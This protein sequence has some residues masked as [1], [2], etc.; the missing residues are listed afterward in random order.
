MGAFSLRWVYCLLLPSCLCCSVSGCGGPTYFC[1]FRYSFQLCMMSHIPSLLQHFMGRPDS[2]YH[3]E[4]NS[5]CVVDLFLCLLAVILLLIHVFSKVRSINKSESLQRLLMHFD[6]VVWMVTCRCIPGPPAFLVN[7]VI[8]EW[9]GN[10][11]MSE[12]LALC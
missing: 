6:L 8:C 1:S 5:L 3:L 9:P 7:V 10:Y 12:L 4:S 2:T 11:I